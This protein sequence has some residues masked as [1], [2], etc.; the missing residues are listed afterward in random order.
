MARTPTGSAADDGDP[1]TRTSLRRELPL[2]LARHPDDTAEILLA[3]IRRGL[4]PP[5]PVAR[6]LADWTAPPARPVVRG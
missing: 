4:A 3:A 1:I 6:L 5:D 2:P